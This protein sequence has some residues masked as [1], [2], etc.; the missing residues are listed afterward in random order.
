MI[1]DSE[2]NG[3]WNSNERLNG[4]CNSNGGCGVNQYY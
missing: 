2:S 4:S 1:T 3:S